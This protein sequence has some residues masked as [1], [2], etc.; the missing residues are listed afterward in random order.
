[1]S[2]FK[3]HLE[4]IALALILLLAAFLNFWGVW[5]E[6]YGNEFYAACVKSMLQ[7]WHNFFFVSFDPGGFVTVDK[8]P[9][10]LW[11]QA[12]SAKLFGFSGWSLILPQALAGVL[13][14]AVLGRLVRRGFGAAAGLTAALALA[15][16]PVFVAVA[17]TNNLDSTLILVLLLAARELW[18][19]CGTGRLRH[20]LFAMLLLGVGFNVKTLQAYLVLPAFLAVY[21][22]AAKLRRAVKV[23]NLLVSLV[24]L[25]AVSLSWCLAVDLTPADQRPYV[26]NSGNNSEL[27]LALGY[28]GLQRLTGS[29]FG[30]RGN[31]NFGGARPEASGGGDAGGF[32][33]GRRDGDSDRA[34]GGDSGESARPDNGARD[35]AQDR[36]AQENGGSP[37]A[38]AGSGLGGFAFGGGAGGGFGG[39]NEGGQRGVL[40]MFNEQ[41]AGQ[42]SWLLPFSLFAMLILALK[43]PRRAGES[44]ERRR[45]LLAALLL[46][47][48]WTLTMAAFFSVAGFFHRYYLA[49]LSPGIAALFGIGFSELW[50][51]FR[52]KG[53]RWALLPASLAA[54]A[55]VQG[56]MLSRYSQDYVRWTLLAVCILAGAA[57]VGLTVLHF[58]KRGG[59]FPTALA[60][61]GLA[62]LLIAPAVWSCTPLVYGS[63]AS[64]PYAGPE[65]A[66]GEGGFSSD[67]QG[68]IDYDPLIDFLTKNNTGQKFLAAVPSSQYAEEIILKTGQPVMSVGGFL[69]SDSI[70]TAESLAEMVR[71][72]E[73]RYYLLADGGM[74]GGSGEVAQWVRENGTEVDAVVWNGSSS[75]FGGAALYDL[76]PSG[77]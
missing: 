64:L 41:M 25:L 39:M 53:W 19:S 31:G 59:R 42:T 77:G 15:V 32:E 47:G 27:S 74:R 24:L 38:P 68:G 66:R 4:S 37:S 43:L 22:F 23:R 13:S 34:F 61:V 48:G 17:K 62:A 20:L 63:Q 73:V 11:V 46:W 18:V 14:V 29:M 44:G 76:T 1:M 2:F 35:G 49:T 65:L 51:S 21:L 58:A 69:G 36:A 10:G 55:T 40:R 5:D 30:G 12:L 57:A 54:T 26:D 75:G 56:V 9:V 67:R 16:S 60:A 52:E 3:K 71:D 7:S 8:P 33:G 70:L 50:R 6:G 72:G 28:N 45:K